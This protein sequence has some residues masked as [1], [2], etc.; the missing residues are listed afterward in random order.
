MESPLTHAVVA[1]TL[2]TGYRIPPPAL[3]YW[4]LGIVCAV[5][6][7]LDAIGFWLGVPYGSLWGHRGITHSILFAAVLSWV[8]AQWIGHWGEMSRARLWSY[9]FLSTLSHGLL[10]ALTDGG[11]G[12]AFFSPFDQTRYFFPFRPIPVSS[13][14]LRDVLGFHGLSVL[15]NEC[16][17]IW[18]PCGLVAAMMWWLDPRRAPI[19]SSE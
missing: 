10:D 13:M 14:S 19:S 17:W 2:A 3:R 16:L 12:I 15:A 11:L 4:L 7:D 6:P 18:I 1:V 9:C 8:L 5:I